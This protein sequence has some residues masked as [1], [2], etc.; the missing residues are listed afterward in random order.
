MDDLALDHDTLSAQLTEPTQAAPLAGWHARRALGFGASD[1]PVLLLALGLRSADATPRYII[2]RAAVT[3]RTAGA[4]RIIAEKA[5]RVAPLK[6][7]AAA[8]R[9]TE[10]ERELLAAWRTMLSR[11]VFY[12]ESAESL[13][14]PDR[15]THADAMLKSA[16]PL[17]DR[18]CPHLTAT[19]DAWGWDALDAEV[20]VELKCSAS[21]RRSLPWYWRDQTMAQLAVSGA[22]YALLVCGEHWSAWHGNDGPI[23]VW[24]VER[25]EDAIGEI[26]D[27]VERGWKRVEEIRCR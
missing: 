12:D 16:W 26:R 11:G 23:R 20:V 9:G 1:V 27:A 4:P 3:N 10:R 22:D 7:G 17:V 21:E 5:G 13:V 19:L 2:E 18:A 24:R 6:A 15:L 25:D 8:A 14:L